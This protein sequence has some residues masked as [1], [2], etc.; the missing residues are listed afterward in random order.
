MATEGATM[1]ASWLV[2]K[3]SRTLQ[4]AA[5]CSAWVKVRYAHFIPFSF[6]A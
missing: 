5:A 3:S 4:I 6:A 2:A 1:T